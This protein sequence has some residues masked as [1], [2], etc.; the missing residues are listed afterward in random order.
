MAQTLAV[1]GRVTAPIEDGQASAAADLGF[2]IN[3]TQKV[4]DDLVF[5]TFPPVT[6]RADDHKPH[7]LFAT[8]PPDARVPTIGELRELALALCGPDPADRA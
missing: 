2:T 1:T 3:Y 8:S 6:V 5:G 7:T 4:N